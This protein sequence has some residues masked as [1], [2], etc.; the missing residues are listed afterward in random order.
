MCGSKPQTT[1]YTHNAMDRKI[2]VKN[3]DTINKWALG[4]CARRRVR[5]MVALLEFQSKSNE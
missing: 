5:K 4:A 2:L 1:T 3:V